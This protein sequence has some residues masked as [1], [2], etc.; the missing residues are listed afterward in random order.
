MP[1]AGDQADHAVAFFHSLPLSNVAGVGIIVQDA[2]GTI[3]A[4]NPVACALTGWSRDELMG[5]RSFTLPQGSIHED[6]SPFRSGDLPSAAAL[7]TSAGAAAVVMGIEVSPLLH[8]WLSLTAVPLSEDGREFV[9]T[10]LADVTERISNT[11]SLS[12]SEA[13]YRILAESASDAICME[14][15]DGTFEWIS[16]SVTGMLGW[17]PEALYGYR[18]VDLVHPEDRPIVEAIVNQPPNYVDPRLIRIRTKSGNHH[19]ISITSHSRRDDSGQVLGTIMTWRNAQTD[20]NDQLTLAMSDA[21]FRSI[22]DTDIDPHIILEPVR[23]AAG[24]IVD[25]TYRDVNLT[26]CQQYQMT[27]EELIG[28]RLLAPSMTHGIASCRPCS[29]PRPTSPSSSTR[30]AEWST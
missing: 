21:L 23:D 5:R 11:R 6:G 17:L 27:R 25:F 12:E 15:A 30:A 3:V 22:L 4:A 29:T 10:I 28:S 2:D 24:R 7:R 8:R 9:L 18:F 13:R 26:A 19:W 20:V 14:T 16:D 1:E